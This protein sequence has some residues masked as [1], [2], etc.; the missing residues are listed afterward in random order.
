MGVKI[1]WRAAKSWRGKKRTERNW[2]REILPRRLLLLPALFR[3]TKKQDCERKT[4]LTDR[5]GWYR[6]NVDQKRGKEHLNT[7]R[8]GQLGDCERIW[9]RKQEE[10]LLSDWL[11]AKGQRRGERNRRWRSYFTLI[12]I[13]FLHCVPLVLCEIHWR[14]LQATMCTKLP[15]LA[16]FLSLRSSWMFLS[17]CLF[18]FRL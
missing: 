15:S 1:V 11:E 4:V 12:M 3:S 14:W 5:W 18:S 17:V 10:R 2:V 13:L 16:F 7:S 6:N 8:K 9:G